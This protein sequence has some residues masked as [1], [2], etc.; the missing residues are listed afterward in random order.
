MVSAE[1]VIDQDGVGRVVAF[2]PT[3]A[4]E[5]IHLHAEWLLENGYV[6]RIVRIDHGN[7]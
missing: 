4:E 6:D 7:D 3:E 5:D 1:I 2:L